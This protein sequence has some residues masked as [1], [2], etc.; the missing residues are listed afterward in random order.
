MA[1]VIISRGCLDKYRMQGV[2]A[3]HLPRS[4]RSPRL[5]A[6]R[7]DGRLS[8][9]PPPRA[10][11]S[12]RTAEERRRQRIILPAH[13]L[14]HCLKTQQPTKLNAPARSI[15]NTLKPNNIHQHEQHR[16]KRRAL[17][18]FRALTTAIL[19]KLLKYY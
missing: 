9:S 16:T 8:Y 4:C 1:M 17:S 18:H 5:G 12:E 3:K 2:G 10:A 6:L 14:H 11:S 19:L 13:V 15:P 7:T